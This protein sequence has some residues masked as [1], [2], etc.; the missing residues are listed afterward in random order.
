MKLVVLDAA[1][2]TSTKP[3]EPEAERSI[4]KPDSSVE[5]SAQLS[6]MLEV[7]MVDADSEPGAMGCANARPETANSSVDTRRD[8]LTG[9]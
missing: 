9:C 2:A 3:P 8:T 4:S 1:V 6:K 7:D 5:L